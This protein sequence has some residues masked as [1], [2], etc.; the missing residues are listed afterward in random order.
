MAVSA[1][2]DE[3]ALSHGDQTPRQVGRISEGTILHA[4]T[5]ESTTVE[6]QLPQQRL[7]STNYGASVPPTDP[8]FNFERNQDGPIEHEHG[9]AWRVCGSIDNDLGWMCCLFKVCRWVPQVEPSL[10]SV[11]CLAKSSRYRVASS[12]CLPT[13]G[14]SSTGWLTS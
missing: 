13:N 3:S 12:D 4:K 5:Y 11:P 8:R 14:G 2:P 6:Q 9:M 10:R 7:L 1:R